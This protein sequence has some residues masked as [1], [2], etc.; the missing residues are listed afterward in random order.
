MDLKSAACIVTHRNQWEAYLKQR[1]I[2]SE[3]MHEYKGPPLDFSPPDIHAPPL[4][5]FNKFRELADPKISDSLDSLWGA[6]QSTGDEN[7][8]IVGLEGFFATK[9]EAA[10]EAWID[11]HASTTKA[12]GRNSGDQ[13]LKISMYPFHRKGRKEYS[14]M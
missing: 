8:L 9:V 2:K 14:L 6:F 12:R 10:A 13:E 7:Q 4:E 11:H 1:R 5:L 3:A